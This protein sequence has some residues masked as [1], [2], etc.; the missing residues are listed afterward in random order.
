[1][2]QGIIGTFLDGVMLAVAV[3]FSE[4]TINGIVARIS[5]SKRTVTEMVAD[6]AGQV[7]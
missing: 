4:A 3:N 1:M 5:P 7:N 6:Y 2:A